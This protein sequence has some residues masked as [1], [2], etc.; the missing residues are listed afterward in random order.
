MIPIQ[1]NKVNTNKVIEHFIIIGDL[2][3]IH[4]RPIGDPPEPYWRS[5]GDLLEIHRR[6]IGDP[7]ETFWRSTGDLLEIHRR[8]IG[9]RDVKSDRH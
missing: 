2:L 8:P 7:P 9:D 4:R 3:E 5:T 6:P 1:I